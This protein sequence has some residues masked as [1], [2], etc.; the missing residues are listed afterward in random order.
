MDDIWIIDDMPELRAEKTAALQALIDSL[1][2]SGIVRAVNVD[3]ALL[4]NVSDTL[5]LEDNFLSIEDKVALYL[6]H[7]PEVRLV[8]VDRD[9]TSYTSDVRSETTI[10]EGGALAARP[11]C[12]YSRRVRLG[13]VGAELESISLSVNQAFI[14]TSRNADKMAKQVIESY[15]GFEEIRSWVNKNPAEEGASESRRLAQMLGVISQAPYFDGYPNPLPLMMRWLIEEA[16]GDFGEL[17]EPYRMGQ[18][19]RKFILPFPGILVDGNHLSA[20][21]N[22]SREDF[23]ENQSFFDSCR[24]EGPFS[25]Y[26]RYWWRYQIDDLLMSTNSQTGSEYISSKNGRMLDFLGDGETEF[27]YC[28]VS[29]RVI[30]RSDSVRLKMAPAGADLSRIDA[31]EA[32]KWQM[33]LT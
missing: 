30:P 33:Y 9:L 7:H 11:V 13:N 29:K 4:Q 8:V 22:L 28:M 15:L 23:D 16:E 25:K 26:S 5:K 31:N 3:E 17:I 1:S 32:A 6:I 14:D 12:A 27:I 24:Y 10:T 2:L 19:L 20:Y 18:L 21:L